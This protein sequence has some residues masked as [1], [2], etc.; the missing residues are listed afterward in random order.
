MPAP[1][2]RVPSEIVT[3]WQ[4]IVDLLAEIIHVPAALVMQ[5]EPPHITVL[6]ASESQGNPYERGEVAD[7]NPG[8]YCATVMKTRRPLLVPD[9]LADEEWKSNPDIKLGMTSYLGF[10]ISWPNGNVFGTICVLDGKRNDY[11]ELYQK[12]LLHCRDVLH[13]LP[14]ISPRLGYGW[15]SNGDFLTPAI[16]SDRKPEPSRGPTI[17][18][19]IASASSESDGIVVSTLAEKSISS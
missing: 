2:P 3:K 11:S 10:P 14:A 12:L 13:T 16:Y 17:T 4:E 18:C 19:A 6:A 5:A 8:L 15:S 9:A 7:L 1:A